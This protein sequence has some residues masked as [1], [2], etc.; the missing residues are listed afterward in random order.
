MEAKIYALVV[1]IDKYGDDKCFPP[2]S[3]AADGA[4]RFVEWLVG[5]NVSPGN[6]TLFTSE[7]NGTHNDSSSISKNIADRDSI[8]KWIN[9]EIV[10]H[11]SNSGDL[12]YIF[13][14]G[15]GFLTEE[16]G[17]RARRLVLTDATKDNRRN[18]HL[19]SL[20]DYLSVSCRFTKQLFFIN[21]CASELKDSHSVN[22][23]ATTLRYYKRSPH[24]CSADQLIFYSSVDF[25]TVKGD[26]VSDLIISQ[27]KEQSPQ[28]LFSEKFAEDFASNLCKKLESDLPL[29][30]YPGLSTQIAGL[31]RDWLKRQLH[32]VR[33]DRDERDVLTMM[34]EE[35]K[36]RRYTSL[37]NEIFLTLGKESQPTQV[38]PLHNRDL[39]LGYT[40]KIK[41]LEGM[42]II[43]IFNN[44]RINGKLLILGQPGSGKTTTLLELAQALVKKAEAD[45]NYPIPLWFELSSWQNGEDIF[46][47]LI[48]EMRSKYQIPSQTGKNLLKKQVILPLLNGLDEIDQKYQKL[49]IEKIN[50]FLKN[51]YAPRYAVICSRIEEYENTKIKLELN[52]AI[53]LK[54]LQD[55][56]IQEYLAAIERQD[57]GEFLVRK[58]ELLDLIRTPLFLSMAV[59]AYPKAETE[60]WKCLENSS[61]NLQYLLD[62]YVKKMLGRSN[63]FESQFYVKTP[64][65]SAA[66]THK[67]LTWLARNMH[68]TEFLI[69]EIQPYMLPKIQIKI[70][71]IIVGLII[72]F[73]LGF[74]FLLAGL[75]KHEMPPLT[76]LIITSITL[77]LIIGFRVGETEIELVEK[78]TFSWSKFL[79]GAL[80]GLFLG[81]VDI[82]NGITNMLSTVICMVPML[83]WVFGVRAKQ[84]DT[85]HF[86][87][88]GINNS[89]NNAIVISLSN[90]LGVVLLFWLSARL[91]G[92][93]LVGL[94]IESDDLL[95][96]IIT[97][98]I[99][100][101][102]LSGMFMGGFTCIKHFVIRLFLYQNGLI[103]WDYAQ[104]LNYSKELRLLVQ[105][106]GRYAFIHPL[107]QKRMLNQDC[108]EIL[109]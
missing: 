17:E 59:L 37:H 15:H 82:T 67:W 11:S 56:Q 64:P 92:G 16:P 39:Q 18:L 36:S 54:P 85:K 45:S 21:S 9:N 20:I 22:N 29:N 8:E 5:N 51:E 97:A 2:L 98:A 55:N 1:G 94:P 58:P 3:K 96:N 12:L 74:T 13:W 30:C 49:C 68:K 99:S 35:I 89:L 88:Q 91:S 70:Y 24:E 52:G 73:F 104:F 40:S 60:E 34:Q 69:E 31:K 65:P 57:L 107:L 72:S 41:M 23:G 108:E 62:A 81:L 93:M 33:C 100:V 76:S 84:I 77:G 109:K 47:W 75:S 86:P 83:G 32:P 19:T 27:L 103:P 106:R 50:E 102:T 7:G 71:K 10:N 38:K 63:S 14:N 48:F 79:D 105:V 25:Q 53:Y 44:V 6:I 80:L 46:Q 43:D 42:S 26:E 78:L 87:N 28:D 4:R 90:G 66:Q 61:E 101:G 95:L